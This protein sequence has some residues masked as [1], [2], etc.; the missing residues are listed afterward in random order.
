[1]GEIYSEFGPGRKLFRALCTLGTQSPTA[2][3]WTSASVLNWRFI[4]L[5]G[6]CVVFGWPLTCRD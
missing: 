3:F 5:M 1:M 6:G 2:G 4:E